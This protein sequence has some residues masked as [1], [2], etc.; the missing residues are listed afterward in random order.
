MGDEQKTDGGRQRNN[1][2]GTTNR[3]PPMR[4]HRALTLCAVCQRARKEPARRYITQRSMTNFLT[5]RIYE[6]LSRSSGS[7]RSADHFALKDRPASRQ[8]PPPDDAG[9][10]ITVHTGIH[11]YTS[12]ILRMYIFRGTHRLYRPHSRA[13]DL[14]P[15]F[16]KKR[17]HPPE[18]SNLQT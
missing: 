1:Y 17:P 10:S 4:S 8:L 6:G 2:M 16:L 7:P 15:L 9:R 5:P 18:A 3:D 11:L 12:T 13:A 14:V